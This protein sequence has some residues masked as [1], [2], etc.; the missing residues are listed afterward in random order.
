MS[1]GDEVIR[2]GVEPGAWIPGLKY[3]PVGV[4]YRPFVRRCELTERW[5]YCEPL[6][7]DNDTW[8]VTVCATEE[9]AKGRLA[10]RLIAQRLIAD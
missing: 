4:N 7:D 1:I 6:D 2:P 5:E 3:D 9:E 8:R 10:G